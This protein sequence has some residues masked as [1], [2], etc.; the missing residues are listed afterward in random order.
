MLR[1]GITGGIA[2]GKSTL[3]RYL[4]AK[5]FAVIDADLVSRE[6]VSPGSKAARQLA[7][8]FGNDFFDDCGQLKRREMGDL[9]FNDPAALEKLNAIMFPLIWENIEDEIAR[10]ARE[11]PGLPLVFVDAALLLES[12]GLAHVDRVWLVVCED[13]IRLRRLM[14][15]DGLTQSQAESR[16]GAQWSQGEKE[17]FADS[18]LRSDQGEE[19]LFAQAERLLRLL[20]L[21]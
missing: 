21:D 8:V 3:S 1:V 6:L 14:D 17:A 19:A 11:N 5:G 16:M 15:R 2:A 18:I 4:S 12:G 7:E 9:V 10:L 20:A 13:E